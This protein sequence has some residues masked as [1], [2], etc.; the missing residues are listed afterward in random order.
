MANLCKVC[1]LDE[2]LV[3]RVHR[4]VPKVPVAVSEVRVDLVSSPGKVARK[5]GRPLL[6][7]IRDRPWERAG[8]S[9]R[10]WYRRRKGK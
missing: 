10:T 7:E 6:G 4:C 8:M 3:G 2:D 5:K 9:E 1:G